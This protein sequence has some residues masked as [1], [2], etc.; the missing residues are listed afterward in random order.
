MSFF[1]ATTGTNSAFEPIPASKKT[2][3]G[4]E[5]VGEVIEVGSGVTD[6]KLGDRVGIRAYMAG[7]DNKDLP[8]CHHCAEGNYNFCTN[9]GVPPKLDY[10]MSMARKMSG[11]DSH[12]NNVLKFLLCI[13]DTRIEIERLTKFEEYFR[14]K[15]KQASGF[16]LGDK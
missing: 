13:R 6:F 2:Y 14:K 3:L 9:Y 4:H 5:N 11:E 15:I 10:Q 16:V 1:R 7:C 12:K 8:R